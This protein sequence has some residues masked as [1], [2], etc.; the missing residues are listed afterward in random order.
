MVWQRPM[1]MH[2]LAEKESDWVWALNSLTKESAPTTLCRHW[3]KPGPFF[4]KKKIR[5]P[6]DLDDWNFTS[7]FLYHY[8]NTH[9]YN[10]KIVSLIPGD[11]WRVGTLHEKWG[12]QAVRSCLSSN[13]QLGIF[14]PTAGC[15]SIVVIFWYKNA[16][17]WRR[18]SSWSRGQVLWQLKDC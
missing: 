3:F 9:R 6:Q 8:N 13:T 7:E 11:T 18:A 2:L 5:L 17:Y 10:L 4:K 14:V 12:F 15:S 16:P 1:E